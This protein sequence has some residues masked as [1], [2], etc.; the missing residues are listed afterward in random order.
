MKTKKYHIPYFC[1][2]SWSK[3]R[4]KFTND[5]CTTCP[6]PN[7]N[8]KY[9]GR[10]KPAYPY[11]RSDPSTSSLYRYPVPRYIELQRSICC[12]ACDIC[13]HKSCIEI[14]AHMITQLK[15]TNKK[16][17]HHQQQQK[18]QHNGSDASVKVYIKVYM[19]TNFFLRNIYEQDNNTI[20]LF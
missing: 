4:H 11:T 13:H 19:S 5:C 9:T 8:V 2:E 16:P 15:K 17:H 7:Y 6:N 10:K 1:T 12:N 18:N 3:L 20:N 14:H